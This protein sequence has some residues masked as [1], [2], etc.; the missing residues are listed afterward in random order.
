MFF[1]L[2][3]RDV[4]RNKM[5]WAVQKVICFFS[6]WGSHLIK[7][8]EEC[9]KTVKCAVHLSSVSYLCQC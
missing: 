4:V 1:F 9:L 2:P 5:L 7:S 3:H 8:V 6:A